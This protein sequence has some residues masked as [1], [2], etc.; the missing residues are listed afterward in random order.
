MSDLLF[1]GRAYPLVDISIRSGGDGRTVEAY[2]AVWDTPVEISDQQGHYREQIA[3]TAFNRTIQKRGDKPWPVMFNH[4]MTI[5]GTP[6][7]EDSMPIGATVEPPR[8]DSRGLVTVSR[9]H[10]TTRA[11][12]ALEAIRSGAISAQSFSGRFVA[13]DPK[14]P[15]GGYAPDR[16]T[17]ELPLVTR[18][19][20]EMREF[21]PAV[22]AA[23][24]TANITGV[25]ALVSQITG[26]DPDEA[27]RELARLIAD[28]TPLDS[29]PV[30]APT[31]GP[32]AED[33]PAGH[34]DTASAFRHLRRL[35]RE[36]GVL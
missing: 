16:R 10:T 27:L 21:G 6:S 17:G 15:R 36:K 12:Q 11:D 19:E 14:P 1:A 31:P 18:T 35:A 2:A 33:S 23:Y 26:L 29:L 8:V 3:R 7:P 28:S 4:G 30:D 5:H 34:S 20:I 24:P 9:Y 25:R 22:F 13:S 32:V